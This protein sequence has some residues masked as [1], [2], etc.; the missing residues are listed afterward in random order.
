MSTTTLP[1]IDQYAIAITDLYEA[2]VMQTGVAA[3]ASRL[4]KLTDQLL[5]DGWTEDDLDEVA[6]SA[7]G[8]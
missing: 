4:G 1:L 7:L 3:A 2:E 5:A 8:D 6:C